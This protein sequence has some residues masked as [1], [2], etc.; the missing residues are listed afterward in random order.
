MSVAEQIAQDL[1]KAMKGREELRTSCLR[2]AK[3][4]LKNEQVARGHEL[5]DEE[6]QAVL[7]SLIRKGRDAAKEFRA[8]NRE[9]MA[10]KEEREVEV[11]CEYLPKQL[12]PDEIEKV[13][14]EV[15]A[16]LS[17]EGSKDLGKLMKAAMPRLAG[18]AQGKEVNEIARRL[19]N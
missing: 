14:T 8:A 9:S 6:V 11:F 3:A 12:S 2:M 19:L 1:K 13:L 17:A 15:I 4:A 16:E 18:K 5:K 7:Q 10:L